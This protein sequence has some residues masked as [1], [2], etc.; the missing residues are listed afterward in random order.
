MCQVMIHWHTAN[1]LYIPAPA[2]FVASIAAIEND[3]DKVQIEDRWPATSDGDSNF[4]GPSEV[5]NLPFLPQS[6][7]EMKNGCISKSYISNRAT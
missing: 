7:L 1:Q 3:H 4:K 6:W 5:W 2:I